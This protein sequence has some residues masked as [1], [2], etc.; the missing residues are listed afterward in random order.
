VRI[1]NLKRGFATSKLGTYLGNYVLRHQYLLSVL[2]S[3]A[4][5]NV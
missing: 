1:E 2:A 3:V 4:L 5:L